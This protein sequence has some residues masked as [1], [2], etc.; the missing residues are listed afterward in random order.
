MPHG[1]FHAMPTVPR[2]AVPWS[3][4]ATEAAD[5]ADRVGARFEPGRRHVLATFT[6]SGTPRVSGVEVRLVE[7][8]LELVPASAGNKGAGNKGEDLRRDARFALHSNPGDGS[9]R[10]G[11]ATLQGRAVPMAAGDGFW[12]DLTGVRLTRAVDG[13]HGGHG[14]LSV[15]TWRPGQG[16]ETAEPTEA[17]HH[18]R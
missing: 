17:V 12:L 5:L 1:P 6:I 13:G 18:R 9:G 3:V 10:D 8:R 4:F 11:D 15:E 14:G 7:G 16:V 2:P